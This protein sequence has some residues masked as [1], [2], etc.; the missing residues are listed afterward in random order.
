MRLL[1]LEK[2]DVH[3]LMEPA[4]PSKGKLIKSF[5]LEKTSKTIKSNQ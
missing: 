5:R 4:D 3:F 2:M 1:L